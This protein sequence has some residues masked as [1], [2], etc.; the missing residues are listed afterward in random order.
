[1]SLAT[2][3]VSVIESVPSTVEAD[4][5]IETDGE[6]VEP[7]QPERSDVNAR[8]IASSDNCLQCIRIL[9]IA[10][11]MPVKKEVKFFSVRVNLAAN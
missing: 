1:M 3:A 6:A 5:V 8:I 9:R 2:V 7:P 11:D 4:A 10:N